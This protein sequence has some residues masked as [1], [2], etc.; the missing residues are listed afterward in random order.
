MF[1]VTRPKVTRARG[2]PFTGD[3]LSEGIRMV[4]VEVEKRAAVDKILQSQVFRNTESLRRLLRFL[5]EKAITGEAD[6]LKEYSV[7]IDAFGKPPSYDPRQDSA[8]RIQVGRLRQK[9][10]EYYLNE[11]KDDLIIVE[12]PKGG[13][14]L[15]FES[16]VPPSRADLEVVSSQIPA[17]A[18]RPTARRG[19]LTI[20]LAGALVLTLAWALWATTEWVRER[21][22]AASVR[23]AW[24]PELETLWA[25]FLE[26]GR[27]IVFAV[28]SPLF[29]GIQGFGNYRNT[30]LN[31]WAD[32]ESD[33]KLASVR[34]LLGDPEIFPHRLYT[35]TGDA[36]ALFLLGKLLGSR[37]DNISFARSADLTWQQFSSNNVV[38]V[39]T[40][41]SFRDLL[42]GM[43][44]QLELDLDSSGIRILHPLKGEPAG[45]NDQTV[46]GYL[47]PTAPDD[48]EVY[49]L[50]TRMPGPNG[51]GTVASFSSNLNPGTLAAIQQFT[52]PRLA[53]S[54]IN[55]LRDSSGGIPRYFQLALRVRFKGGVPT[56][57]SY[58]LHRV[59]HAST[60][61]TGP[62]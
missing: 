23:A 27:T 46:R 14:R 49:A 26:S 6:Q 57:T 28:S 10:S 15:Q 54:L 58:V 16:R 11:G 7:G 32:V 44:A 29:V 21:R 52:E 34:R 51:E 37:K 22:L 62:K 53:P 42:Q 13:F 40:P 35:G 9:L 18:P 2:A 30:T 25:P 41:R 48:G 38:L 47:S 1:A 50:I 39:G 59:L 8:V 24:T 60:A 43:P 3:I 5:A 4:F 56:E 12:L 45:L 19:K 61:A 33:A 55:R 17:P 31:S 36:N 20:A